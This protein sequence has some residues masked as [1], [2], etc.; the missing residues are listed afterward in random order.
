M[1]NLKVIKIKEQMYNINLRLIIGNWKDY[2]RHIKNVYNIKE[3][4]Q[5]FYGGYSFSVFHKETGYTEC[6]VWLPHFNNTIYEIGNLSHECLH[7][8]IK[9]LDKI[10]INTN[11]DNQEPLCYLQEYFLL[12][13]L[14][15][16]VK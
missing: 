9:I 10:G 16:L 6:I 7:S 2:C 4:E 12:R 13:C 14:E 8:A 3:K 1:N 15:K 11:I 5:R